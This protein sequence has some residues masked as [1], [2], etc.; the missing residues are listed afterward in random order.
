[1]AETKKQKRAVW[2]TKLELFD[3]NGVMSGSPNS[4]NKGNAAKEQRCESGWKPGRSKK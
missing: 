3:F 2:Y 4:M 1:M